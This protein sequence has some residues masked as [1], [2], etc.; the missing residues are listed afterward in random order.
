MGHWLYPGLK[1]KRWLLVFSFGLLLTGSGLAIA[2]DWRVYF[3][4]ALSLQKL[5][6]WSTGTSFPLPVQGMIIVGLGLIVMAGAIGQIINRLIAEAVP[7]GSADLGRMIIQKRNLGLGPKIV[8]IGGGTGLPVLLRGLKQFTSNITAIVT[9]ADD[10]G[11]SGRLRGEYGILPPGDLRN[12]LV[13]LADIEG[14]MEKLFQ[15]RFDGKSPLAGHSFGNLFILAMSAV[16]GDFEEAIRQSSQV[17]AIKGRVVPSTTAQVVLEAEFKDGR[18]IRGESAISK[19]G[20]AI[21]RV[22]LVPSNPPAVEEAVR[23]IAEA[24]AVILGPGSLYTSVLPNLLV[25]GLAEAIRSSRA[26]KIYVCNVMTQPGETD[27]FTCVDHVKALIDHAGHGLIQY[28]LANISPI[29][30]EALIRYQDQGA[31]PVKLANQPARYPVEVVGAHLLASEGLAR[32]DPKKLA[33][34]IIRLILTKNGFSSRRPWEAFLWREQVEPDL[35]IK[36]KTGGG[37]H[38]FS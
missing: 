3:W 33:A 10:G 18:V 36:K 15:H 6:F 24:D 5:L 21:R 9:V 19:V 38:R 28:C 23:A 20:A 17:L 22:K 32:H 16:T 34:A 27:G 31:E 12:C 2:L 30:P 4:L 29:P 26:L 11:S 25:P 13:A 14:L 7:G 8:A 1:L 37:F 35:K